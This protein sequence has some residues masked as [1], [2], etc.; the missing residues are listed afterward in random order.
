MRAL[1]SGFGADMLFDCRSAG[2]GDISEG[3]AGAGIVGL[4]LLSAG[5][6]GGVAGSVE[7]S[8]PGIGGA[9]MDQDQPSRAAAAPKPDAPP[10]TNAIFPAT[11]SILHSLSR[12]ITNAADRT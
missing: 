8:I 12:C 1:S 5:A 11:L 6:G 3:A 9:R 10:V 7:F 4:A 2:V